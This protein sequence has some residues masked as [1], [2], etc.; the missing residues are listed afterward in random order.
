MGNAGGRGWREGGPPGLL[1]LRI[2]G[3]GLELEGPVWQSES[4][5]D[6]ASSG[7]GR[8]ERAAQAAAGGGNADL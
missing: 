2:G 7:A 3:D 5:R 1:A 8:Y 4:L 6:Q